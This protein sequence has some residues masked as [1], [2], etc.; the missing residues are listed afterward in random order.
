[1]IYILGVLSIP[2]L[3]FSKKM[4]FMCNGYGWVY[5][6]YIDM[7]NYNGTMVLGAYKLK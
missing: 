3:F 7:K 6:P 5:V 1:M 2:F 4:R